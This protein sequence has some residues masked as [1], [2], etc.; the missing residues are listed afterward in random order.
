MT[1]LVSPIPISD[2]WF[3]VFGVLYWFLWILGGYADWFIRRRDVGPPRMRIG[4]VSY[5]ALVVFAACWGAWAVCLIGLVALAASIWLGSGAVR[6][7]W[8]CL[9]HLNRDSGDRTVLIVPDLSRRLGGNESLLL[10]RVCL[11]RLSDAE[12]DALLARQAASP[13]RWPPLLVL[14]SLPLAFIVGSRAVPPSLAPFVSIACILCLWPLTVWAYRRLDAQADAKAIQA[15]GDPATYI[16]AVVKADRLMQEI[17]SR[18]R[19]ST[20]WL[21]PATLESR[22]AAITPQ[23]A[24]HP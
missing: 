2:I 17:P 24:T 1:T 16:Q 15:T 8:A 4:P 13:S 18:H 14:A 5:T 9:K 7:G 23:E 22:I 19:M 20:W 11:D 21:F 10:P 12:V 3:W 6:K